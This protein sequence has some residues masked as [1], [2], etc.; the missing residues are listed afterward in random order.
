M[1]F[2]CFN[3]LFSTNNYIQLLL[4]FPYRNSYQQEVDNKDAE[5]RQINARYNAVENQAK[6][7]EV[8]G[9]L[10]WHGQMTLVFIRNYPRGENLLEKVCLEKSA[11]L[12]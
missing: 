5:L 2:R 7:A 6:A 10:M 8:R 12:I 1:K 11:G 3:H 9:T 4:H